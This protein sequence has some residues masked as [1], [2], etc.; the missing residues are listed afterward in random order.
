MIPMAYSS[1]H[2]LNVGQMAPVVSGKMLMTVNE[3]ARNRRRS[4]VAKA[5]RAAEYPRRVSDFGD[6]STGR[7]PDNGAV[8]ASITEVHL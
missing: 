4:A 6:D 5:A 3:A 7:N 2:A 8:E 1:V